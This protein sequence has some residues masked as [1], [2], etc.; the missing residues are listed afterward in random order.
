MRRILLISALLVSASAA[1]SLRRLLAKASLKGVEERQ[2]AAH[3]SAQRGCRKQS[4][5]HAVVSF[6]CLSKLYLEPV[7]RLG[8][9]M[10]RP[11]K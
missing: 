8:L 7:F 10:N 4:D 11:A 3:L 5:D 2:S 1:C 6:T 9:D